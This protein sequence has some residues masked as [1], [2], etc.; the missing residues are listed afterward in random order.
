MNVRDFMT[1]SGIHWWIGRSD[2]AKYGAMKFEESVMP[3]IE[4]VG[5]SS[6]IDIYLA[7]AD[8]TQLNLASSTITTPYSATISIEKDTT[9]GNV[10]TDDGSHTYNLHWDLL[11]K[12]KV[13]TNLDTYNL[14]SGYTYYTG[15][16]IQFNLSIPGT[17][18]GSGYST[19][20]NIPLGPVIALHGDTPNSSNPPHTDSATLKPIAGN[21]CISQTRGHEWYMGSDNAIHMTSNG[22]V[23]NDTEQSHTWNVT[24]SFNGTNLTATSSPDSGYNRQF[25][26]PNNASP[27]IKIQHPAS[28]TETSGSSHPSDP[29]AWLISILNTTDPATG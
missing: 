13:T 27:C 9:G 15:L 2:G 7:F 17:G 16:P 6:A 12:A 29:G 19:S 24:W 23:N 28:W 3:P 18:G 10:S 26:Y 1:V 21:Q 25:A 22:N 11:I 20:F 5:T 8:T 4:P 14:N